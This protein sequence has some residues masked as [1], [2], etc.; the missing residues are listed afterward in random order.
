[1]YYRDENNTF[2]KGI[3][4]LKRKGKGSGKIVTGAIEYSGTGNNLKTRYI[5]DNDECDIFDFF[6]DQKASKLLDNKFHTTQEWLEATHHLDYPLY[7]DLIPR[8]FKN[9]RACDLILSNDGS[10]VFNMKNGKV[11]NKNIHNHDLGVR[12]CMSV[13]LI[14]SGSQEIPHKVIP[15]CKITDI[16]PTLLKMLGK[17]PHSSVVGLSLI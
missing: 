12:E 11:G 5:I 13:P 10:V 15:F 4:H 8:H 3:I 2:D 6:K 7:P 17:E 1:M 16:V 9:P 14:I